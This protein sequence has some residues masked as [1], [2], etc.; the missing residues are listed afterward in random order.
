VSEPIDL[1]AENKRR[2]RS[3]PAGAASPRSRGAAPVGSG[4]LSDRDSAFAMGRSSEYRLAGGLGLQ[5][6]DSPDDVLDALG[7]RAAA[8]K[9]PPAPKDSSPAAREADGLLG[10]FEGE[11]VIGE[12][13]RR[14]HELTH[15]QPTVSVAPQ[16]SAQLAAAHVRQPTRRRA[17]GPRRGARHTPKRGT[18]P[19]RAVAVLAC[20]GVAAAA[21]AA[22]ILLTTGSPSPHQPAATRAAQREST[23]ANPSTPLFSLTDRAHREIAVALETAA[24][25]TRQRAA[26]QARERR[27]R[28]RTRPQ[29]RKR[30]QQRTRD[31]AHDRAGANGL[32]EP[33]ATA[34]TSSQTG[35]LTTTSTVG[36]VTTTVPSSSG[37]TSDSSSGPAGPT[38]IGSSSEGCD[39]QCR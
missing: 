7:E 26:R 38:G 23:N 20:L 9:A 4:D 31:H 39:P 6:P 3:T 21:A 14:H 17:S 1:V 37:A 30:T 34:S 10:A 32:K 35:E 12:R 11:D 8:E 18:A 33:Q 19:R 25:R 28:Q 15:A 13:L 16:G 5:D 2:K 29:Q 36:E 27:E 22:V 24:Q